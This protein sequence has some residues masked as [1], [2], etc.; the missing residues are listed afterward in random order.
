[1][2]ARLQIGN[3][4]RE[5]VPFIIRHSDIR[6]DHYELEIDFGKYGSYYFTG[7]GGVAE[8]HGFL[9]SIGGEI[10]QDAG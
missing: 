8:A 7:D 2:K 6:G 9:K 10:I 5:G 1:M 4:M 3:E